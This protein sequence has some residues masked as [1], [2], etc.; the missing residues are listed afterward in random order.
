MAGVVIKLLPTVFAIFISIYSL[1]FTH[2]EVKY[3]YLP[4][5]L[6]VRVPAVS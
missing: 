2:C 3:L 6:V 1:T 5:V 4:S